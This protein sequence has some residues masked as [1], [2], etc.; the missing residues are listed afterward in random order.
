MVPSRDS[1]KPNKA[2]VN[3]TNQHLSGGIGYNPAGNGWPQAL[4]DDSCPAE[5][6]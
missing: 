4:T 2:I 1:L 5:P 6:G 3:T